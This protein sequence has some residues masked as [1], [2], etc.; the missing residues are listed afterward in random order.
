MLYKIGTS[1]FIS[2]TYMLMDII[3]VVGR[4]NLFFQKE[5]VDVA[6]VKV[7]LDHCLHQLHSLKTVPGPYE[8]QLDTDL[9]I[10]AKQFKQ[11]EISLSPHHDVQSVKVKFLNNLIGNITE[12]FPD[13]DLLT[14]F[15]VLSMR[16]VG[17]LS[18]KDLHDWGDE[19]INVLIR[20]FGEEKEHT[21]V[22]EDKKTNTSKSDLRSAQI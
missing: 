16:P 13:T 20:H 5:N 22:D 18:G 12:R 4:L 14:A 11:H 21:W 2:M 10:V 1:K 6:L 15:G 17:L 19:A 8:H 3:P 9:D 7:N